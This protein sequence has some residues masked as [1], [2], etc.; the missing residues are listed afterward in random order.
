M[1][2]EGDVD[3]EQCTTKMIIRKA[4]LKH[5]PQDLRTSSSVTLLKPQINK[6]NAMGFTRSV[7]PAHEVKRQRLERK[8]QAEEE[9]IGKISDDI[10]T[11]IDG[12]NTNPPT[13]EPGEDN[14]SG[15]NDVG[16]DDDIAPTPGSETEEPM[17]AL[18][19]SYRYE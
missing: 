2:K 10:M 13:Y 6:L 9:L 15:N 5:P 19:P 12:N 4:A 17:L 16:G 14:C 8:K 11:L 3:P 7:I 18:P 1:E